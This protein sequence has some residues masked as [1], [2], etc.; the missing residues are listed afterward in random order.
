MTLE[1]LNEAGRNLCQNCYFFAPNA[2]PRVPK[3]LGKCLRHPPVAIFRP[4]SVTNLPIVPADFSQPVVEP[5]MS[6]GEF[7][8]AG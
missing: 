4:K 6:C 5:R 7:R 2:Q 8:K 1:K 3:G